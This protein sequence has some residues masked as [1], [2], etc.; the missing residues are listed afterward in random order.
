MADDIM[1][2]AVIA[3]LGECSR[4][5]PQCARCSESLLPSR[6][7]DLGP[8]GKTTEPRLK[9]NNKS[10]IGHYACLSYCWGGAQ[11][12]MTTQANIDGYLKS[13]N[14]SSLSKTIQDPIK[15][16]RMLHL[17]YLWIDAL[18]IIQDSPEDKRR[19]MAYMGMIYKNATVT[20][21]AA[22][23][24]SSAR[25]SSMTGQWVMHNQLCFPSYTGPKAL[26]G[27]SK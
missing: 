2:K 23:A 20:I 22:R 13:L 4:D 24:K 16:T 9:I 11:E 17:R 7:I 18:C 21:A 5:H 26:S 19:E 10:E 3:H 25:A 14:L 15:V 12:Y 1:A 6:I 8:P 27:V